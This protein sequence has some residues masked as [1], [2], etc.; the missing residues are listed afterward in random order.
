MCTANLLFGMGSNSYIA[1][2]EISGW[3]QKKYKKLIWGGVNVHTCV[4]GR[5]P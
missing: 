5:M 3:T 1:F 2:L 4:L